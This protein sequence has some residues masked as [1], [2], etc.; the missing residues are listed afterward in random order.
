[1]TVKPNSLPA[2]KVTKPRFITKIPT[3]NSLLKFTFS[4]SVFLASVV[5]IGLYL[6]FPVTTCVILISVFQLLMLAIHSDIK[7]LQALAKSTIPLAQ[8]YRLIAIEKLGHSLLDLVANHYQQ[9]KRKDLLASHRSIAHDLRTSLIKARDAATKDTNQPKP[10]L[11]QLSKIDFLSKK[12]MGGMEFNAFGS[13]NVKITL[14]TLIRAYSSFHPKLNI[15]FECQEEGKYWVSTS[16]ENIERL[17][18]AIIDNAIASKGLRQKEIAVRLANDDFFA[19]IEVEDNGAGVPQ[20]VQKQLFKKKIFRSNQTTR[21]LSLFSAKRL[22]DSENGEIFFESDILTTKFQIKLPLASSQP[23]PLEKIILKEQTLVVVVD[24]DP[25]MHLFWQERAESTIESIYSSE[26]FALAYPSFPKENVLFIFDYDL[27]SAKS[28]L[29]LIKEYDLYAQSILV[30]VYCSH[31]EW[32]SAKHLRVIDKEHLGLVRIIKK[33]A[34]TAK[35]KKVVHLDDDLFFQNQF[36]FTCDNLAIPVDA[37]S[38]P[39]D[40]NPNLYHEDSV[41]FLDENY[42]STAIKGRDIAM[43]LFQ[44]GFKNIYIQS[45]VEVNQAYYFKEYIDKGDEARITGLLHDFKRTLENEE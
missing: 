24:D 43:H 17:S 42:H 32:I 29:C 6:N 37:L 23:M 12:I 8:S 4:I 3:S 38:D 21:G 36:L 35:I 40:L 30:S 25:A 15:K 27:R 14:E 44:L 2:I 34:G 18:R 19:T 7:K 11:E 39:L 31:L 22:L 41:F 28:G 16:V 5:A 20:S 9:E 10:I 13:S 33:Q 26:Q 45:A 1:M